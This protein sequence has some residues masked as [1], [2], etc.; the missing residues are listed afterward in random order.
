MKLAIIG[1]GISGLVAAYRLHNRHEITLFEALD[2]VGGHT[3]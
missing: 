2:Y 1:S 3:H